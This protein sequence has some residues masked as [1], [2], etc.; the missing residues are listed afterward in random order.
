M[1][2]FR[3]LRGFSMVSAA[4]LCFVS[5][6]VAHSQ[7]AGAVPAVTHP[8]TAAP[9]Q[10]VQT[11]QPAAAPANTGTAP[12]T[13]APQSLPVDLQ[14]ARAGCTTKD[15]HCRIRDTLAVT[16]DNLFAWR[17]DPKAPGNDPEKLELVLNG[18]V[19]TGIL[20]TGPNSSDPNTLFFSLKR[21]DLAEGDPV[22][23]GNRDAW[24]TLLAGAKLFGPGRAV[25]VGVAIGGKPPYIGTTPV[26]FNVLPHYWQVVASFH[27]AMLLLFLLL[28]KNSDMLRDGATTGAP[29]QSLWK[30]GRRAQGAQPQTFSL[31]RCQ[32][33]WW[34]FIV[35][36]SYSFIWMVTGDTDTLTAGALIL[37][38]I[39][40]ATGFSSFLVDSSK[41]D[42]RK[43]LLD[44]LTALNARLSVLGPLIDA[45][46]AL[47]AGTKP[48][49]DLVALTTELQQKQAQLEQVA[50]QLNSLPSPV[51]P[52][53]GFLKDILSDETGVSFHRFQMAAWTVV[54]G[55]VFAVAVNKGLAMPD[56]SPT[57]LGLM[58]ISAGT[59]V[60]FK[61]PNPNK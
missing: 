1:D 61:I 32:M 26:V 34:F 46:P 29:G 11:A 4:V 39:S 45:F 51:G 59:Y 60:G 8:A 7:A 10:I 42:Q 41:A 6:G 27:V 37:M 38:G 2:F 54:L 9:V 47:P 35:V 52:S 40:A 31:A 58:G 33:A 50:T 3:S 18:T 17:T 14:V 5:S 13:A 44:Q 55:C 36:A 24:N 19:M 21:M 57:L 25:A 12:V 23:K 56:F 20:A 28:A 16:F 53:Q 43:T 48:P 30:L 22:S 15:G 49:A